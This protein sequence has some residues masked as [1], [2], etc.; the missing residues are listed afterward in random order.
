MAA[1]EKVFPL[2]HA[3]E[4]FSILLHSNGLQDLRDNMTRIP[5]DEGAFR[6]H[7]RVVHG[8]HWVDLAPDARLPE[9]TNSD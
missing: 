7:L 5:R 4:F 6:A 8:L 9:E 1:T 2:S 3:M